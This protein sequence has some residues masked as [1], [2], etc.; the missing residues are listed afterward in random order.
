[1]G[2]PDSSRSP[3]MRSDVRIMQR[4]VSRLNLED[5]RLELELEISRLELEVSKSLQESNPHAATVAAHSNPATRLSRTTPK[6]APRS[7]SQKDVSLSG[8]TRIK[9]N[10]VATVPLYQC[11]TPT[12]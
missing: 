1:M 5:K 2:L 10:P 4:A 8:S 11:P 3:V 6:P 7:V 9:P 12:S